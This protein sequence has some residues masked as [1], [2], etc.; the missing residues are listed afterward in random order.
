MDIVVFS[1]D[2]ELCEDFCLCQ[3]VDD[4]R[5]ERQWITVLDSDGVKLLIVLHEAE[6]SILLFDEKDR[7]YHR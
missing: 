1:P 7:G 6:F 2:V 5:R 4:I 3:A